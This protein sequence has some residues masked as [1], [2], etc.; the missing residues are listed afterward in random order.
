MHPFEILK[1]NDLIKFTEG[2]LKTLPCPDLVTGSERVCRIETDPDPALVLHLVYNVGY[3]LE[4]M[5]QIGSLSRCVFNHSG[6]AAGLLQREVDRLG[7]AVKTTI[8]RY[9]VQ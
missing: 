3:L 7:D 9:L 5:S 1:T 8:N 2:I 4:G 6:D